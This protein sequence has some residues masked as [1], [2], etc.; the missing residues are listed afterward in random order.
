MELGLGILAVSLVI[1]YVVWQTRAKHNHPNWKDRSKS[2]KRQSMENDPYWGI[3]VNYH[4]RVARRE[5]LRQNFEGAQGM[6]AAAVQRRKTRG[7][8]WLIRGIVVVVMIL[9]IYIYLHTT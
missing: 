8:R 6:H 9:G 1:G 7:R 5:Q 4:P 3:H 2:P